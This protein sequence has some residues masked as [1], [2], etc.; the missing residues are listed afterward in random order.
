MRRVASAPSPGRSSLAQLILIVPWVAL[1]IA[2]WSPLRDNSFLWHIR[3]GS[4]QANGIQVLTEDPFSFTMH[5]EQWLTQSWL[6]ELFYDWAEMA[7]GMG[8]VPLMVLFLSS[9]TMV[10]IGLISYR[11]SRSVSATA[12]VLVLSTFL[13]ISFLV[14]RP[15]IF[16]FTLFVLVILAW[17]RPAARW[18]LPFL[19]WVWASVHGSFLIGLGYVLL[20]LIMRREWKWLRVPVVSGVLTLAT[21][22]G[23]GVVTMLVAFGEARDT[24]LLLSEWRRPEWWSAAFLPLAGGV[25]IIVYGALRGRITPKH[26]WLLVPFLL[27]GMSA[28]RA[29]PSAWLAIVPLIAIALGDLNVGGRKRFS[30]GATAVFVSLVLVLPFL[31]RDDGALDPE[32]FPLTAVGALSEVNTF[33][34]DV[35]GGYLI[36]VEGPGRMVYLDDRAELYQE[37]IGEFVAVRNGDMAWEPVFARDEIGQVLLKKGEHLAVELEAAG[38]SVSYADVS[39]VVLRP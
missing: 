7:T 13:L 3:A 4:I 27:L 39:F 30:M 5:G 10:G 28:T 15:V 11:A 34:D 16:S 38:W 21:A 32:R 19:F 20:S 6:G 9:L 12:I 2:A 29:I 33:H 31:I 24:L 26:L 35:T 37:R 36:W 25:V 23:L 1:V 22:H 17:E 14:P 18:T 8:F